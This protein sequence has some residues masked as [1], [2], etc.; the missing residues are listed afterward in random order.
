MSGNAEIRYTVVTVFP[1]QAVTEYAA[2][3]MAG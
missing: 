3:I 1:P 2:R